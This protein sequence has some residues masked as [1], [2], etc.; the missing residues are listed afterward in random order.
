VIPN[1]PT[2]YKLLQLGRVQLQDVTQYNHQAK[3]NQTQ[4][5]L[6]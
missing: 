4:G 6:R 1:T 3:K 5:G 2:P